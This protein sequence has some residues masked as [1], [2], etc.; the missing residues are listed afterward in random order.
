MKDTISIFS[1]E[2]LKAKYIAGVDEV[3]RGPLA[4][5]VVGAAV[6]FPDGYTHPEITDSKK[7]TRKKREEL[8]PII[9]S[10]ALS[11]AIVAVGARRV[12]KLNIREAAKLAM[13]MALKRA[14]FA[15]TPDLV[16]VDGNM[17][18]DTNYL[19]K[20]IVSGDALRIE[21]G[22]ASII[23]KVWRDRLMTKLDKKYPGYGF[24]ANSGY[25]TKLHLESLKS[26]GPTKIHRKSFKGVKA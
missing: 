18:I 22:A 25:G 15:F 13:S 11:W 5:P 21:I 12:D 4:G 20:T 24:E 26:L 3:G 1:S 17:R 8:D 7:L 2:I 19:Q 10:Q 9:R 14:S 23:A 16:L 6:I